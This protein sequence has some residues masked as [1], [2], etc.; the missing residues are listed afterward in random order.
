MPTKP[1]AL[2]A[3][4][5]RHSGA[6]VLV[7]AA[8]TTAG[9]GL[10]AC[11]V[12]GLVGGSAAALG[13]LVGALIAVAVFSFGSFT[14]HTVAGLMPSASMLFALLTY[15]LQVLLL[16]LALVAIEEAGLVE[17]TLDR[18]WLAGGIIGGTLVWMVAQVVWT[19]RARIP[20]FDLPASGAGRTGPS[21][22]AG[23]R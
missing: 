18:V 7:W 16:L 11:A 6:R 9:L 4:P 21:T 17:D 20:V 15:A 22:D 14:V 10:V 8:A 23:D 13:V 5:H 19:V 12:G 1:T 2:S 3:D